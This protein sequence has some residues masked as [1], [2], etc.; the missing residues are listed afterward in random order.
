LYVIAEIIASKTPSE[1]ICVWNPSTH[2]RITPM[3]VAPPIKIAA[4]PNQ[5]QLVTIKNATR[6]PN[7]V[8]L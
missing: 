7:N 6:L 4:D 1:I 3:D 2:V 8:F 5:Q